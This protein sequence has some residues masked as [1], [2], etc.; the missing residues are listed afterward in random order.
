MISDGNF[1]EHFSIP[2][3]DQIQFSATEFEQPA[4]SI[5]RVDIADYDDDQ[6]EFSIPVK[7]PDFPDGHGGPP[8]FNVDKF[9]KKVRWLYFLQRF[10]KK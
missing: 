3:V 10:Q 9:T 1:G 6:P 7:F 8:A 2:N 4:F 5:P